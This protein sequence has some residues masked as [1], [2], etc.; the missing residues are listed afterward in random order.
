M[1]FRVYGVLSVKKFEL[2]KPSGQNGPKLCSIKLNIQQEEGC[3]K[4][5]GEKIGS[6]EE[7]FLFNDPKEAFDT[8]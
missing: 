4:K 2:E 1:N 3:R 8:L 5:I 7:M 6:G